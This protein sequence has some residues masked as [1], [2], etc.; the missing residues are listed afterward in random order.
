MLDGNKFGNLNV[1]FLT[2]RWR[3]RWSVFAVGVSGQRCSWSDASWP[4]RISATWPVDSIS[5]NSIPVRA[6]LA[7][8]FTP[9]MF[10]CE[11]NFYT[12]YIIYFSLHLY[13]ASTPCFSPTGFFQILL[14]FLFSCFSYFPLLCDLQVSWPLISWASHWWEQIF[15]ASWRRRRRSSASAGRSWEL[16]TRLLAI[17]IQSTWRYDE[18]SR[19]C[20]NCFPS[21]CSPEGC[22]S[23]VCPLHALLSHQGKIISSC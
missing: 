23:E 13:F 14:F 20:S 21:S 16:F 19:R 10:L 18:D 12:F 4:I 9:E 11:L 2:F 15:V 5:W 17:T 1:N 22:R 8:T 6:L 3:E 7:A